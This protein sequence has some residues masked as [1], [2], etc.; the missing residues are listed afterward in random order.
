MLAFKDATSD[1]REPKSARLEQ[2]TKPKVKETIEKAA[3]CL[4]VDTSDFV[5]SAAYREAVQ[6][7]KS[8]SRTVLDE[9]ASR[10]FFAAL[11]SISSPNTAML[12]L[13]T[14]Y[15]ATTENAIR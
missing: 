14:E 6:T 3:A 11:E 4:G 8:Q 5:T 13:M 7:L 2:R 15:E 12:D 9:R 1:V 10:A